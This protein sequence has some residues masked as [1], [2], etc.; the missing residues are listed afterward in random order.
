[1]ANTDRI[2]RLKEIFRQS[3]HT[4]RAGEKQ[5]VRALAES[6]GLTDLMNMII[7]NRFGCESLEDLS[8]GELAEL[9]ETLHTLHSVKAANTASN[10]VAFPQRRK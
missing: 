10:V 7:V 4:E 3:F 1:M 5:S 8:L 6:L 2:E 9:S